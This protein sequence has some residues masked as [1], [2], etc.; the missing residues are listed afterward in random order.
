[1]GQ[2]ASYTNIG[3]QA[4]LEGVMMKSPRFISLAVR[5]PSGSIHVEGKSYSRWATKIPILAWPILRGAAGIFE[6]MVHGLDALAES[7]NVLSLDTSSSPA[8]ASNENTHLDKSKKAQSGENP[9]GPISNWAMAGTIFIS[10]ALGLLLFVALPHLLTVWG[11]SYIGL[12]TS[13]DNP[14]FHGVD[15]VIKVIILLLYIYLIGLTRD[16]RR[17]F[18]YHGAEHKSVYAFEAGKALTVQNAMEQSTLHPR[19]GTS[20]LLFLVLTSIL[21]F[22]VTLPFFSFLGFE[23]NPVFHHAI[24]IGSKIL[25]MIPVA[26]IAYEFIKFCA[27]RMR[28]PFLRV[29]IWPGLQLQRL[30]TKAPDEQQLEIALTALRHVLLLEKGELKAPAKMEVRAL[31]DLREPNGKVS[32]FLEE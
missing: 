1:M 13:G 18:Q 4:V 30:T 27:F 17:V 25:L 3:G 5:L 9:S 8:T 19:C 24:L 32:E 15:G 10:I 11:F 23:G 31:T 14:I 12:S 20:F 6:S 28:N 21:V 26:G 29:L 16:I 2:G 22:S 7:A